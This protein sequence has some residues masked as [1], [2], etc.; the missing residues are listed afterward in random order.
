MRPPSTQPTDTELS[1]LRVLWEVG[2]ATVRQVHDVLSRERD[3]GYT[4]VLKMMQTM[5]EKGLLT[6]D[7]SDRSHVYAAAR[8]RDN[9]RKSLL[10][11]LLD[12]AFGGSARELV[13]MALQS[14]SL[15]AQEKAEIQTLL[16]ERRP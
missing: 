7:E 5:T 8:D 9:T 3:L 6:R 12:K 1:I 13:V 16:K 10:R 15:N 2:P 4:T 11:D 14:E